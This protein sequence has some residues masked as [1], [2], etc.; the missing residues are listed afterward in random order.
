MI[1]EVSDGSLAL[2][3]WLRELV[4]LIDRLIVCP[5]D[6]ITRSQSSALCR[7][8]VLDCA[9]ERAAGPILAERLCQ[10]GVHVLD[11][12]ADTAA[13]HATR[14]HELLVH[15]RWFRRDSSTSFIDLC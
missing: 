10:P 14:F 4:A 15:G 13:H 11:H 12:D 7:T 3:R 1:P 9:Y 5:Q 8:A 6:H 2:R